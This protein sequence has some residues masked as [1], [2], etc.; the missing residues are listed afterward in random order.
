MDK[1]AAALSGFSSSSRSADPDEVEE[2]PAGSSSSRQPRGVGYVRVDG[3]HDSTERLTA[4]QR[5]RSDPTI[6]VALLSI[7]AA[8][9]GEFA[10]QLVTT[11]WPHQRLEPKC[12]LCSAIAACIK[13]RAF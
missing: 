10:S 1:L 7:T 9:V 13:Y 3:S 4:V 8:A 2:P 11:Q 6:R 12:L 5:F